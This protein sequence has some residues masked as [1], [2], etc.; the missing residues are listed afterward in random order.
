[1]K[2]ADIA[3]SEHPGHG[4]I[5]VAPEGYGVVVDGAFMEKHRP[6][7]GGYLVIYADGYKSFSPEKAFE[8]GYTLIGMKAEVQSINVVKYPEKK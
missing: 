6:Q 8:E 5:L 1:M 7:I 3:P 2:I 4:T